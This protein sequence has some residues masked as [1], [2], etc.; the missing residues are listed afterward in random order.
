MQEQPSTQPK[1]SYTEE[2]NALQS[3]KRPALD[4]HVRYKFL[5]EEVGICVIPLEGADENNHVQDNSNGYTAEQIQ[6]EGYADYIQTYSTKG[7]YPMVRALIEQYD[8]E[9]GNCEGMDF[10]EDAVDKTFQ[11]DNHHDK[12]VTAFCKKA[13]CNK[14]DVA[15]LALLNNNERAGPY[16]F[17]L[18][19]VVPKLFCLGWEED[20]RLMRHLS[21]ALDT[22]L[23]KERPYFDDGDDPYCP[24]FS[25]TYKFNFRGLSLYD[26]EPCSI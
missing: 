7:E 6:E 5:V 24:D 19:I 11:F 3:T 18:E 16:D 22:F 26:T 20:N 9:I 23:Q 13:K 14:D 2:E 10:I 21:S 1:R 8:L 4:T 25:A 15:H 12:L 17:Y